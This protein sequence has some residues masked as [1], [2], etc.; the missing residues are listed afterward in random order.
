MSKLLPPSPKGIPFFRHALFFRNDPLNFMWSAAKK[1]GGVV[2][3]K[4]FG[5]KVYLVSDANI[6]QYVM[7]KNH[8]NY[9]KS[10]GY[11]PLRLLVGN[12]TFTSEGAFWRSEERRVGNERSS[13]P[14]R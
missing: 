2:L 10:P 4:V 3:F 13:G 8:S 14:C 1:Y 12:G 9:I 11:K 7:Q 5:K 6:A